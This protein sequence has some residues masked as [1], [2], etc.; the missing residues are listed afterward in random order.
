MA[1]KTGKGGFKENPQNI[2]KKGAPMRGESW[3]EI[4]DRVGKMTPIEAAEHAK[5]IA[6]KLK[7]MGG[8]MTLKEAVV[9]RGYAALLFEP[10]PGL[11]NVY[12]D[13][14]DGK[15]ETPIKHSGEVSMSWKEFI[16]DD[17][18]ENSG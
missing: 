16:S 11:M 3:A 2:N 5:A 12:M 17:T 18:E 10:S 14:N 15:V 8:D 13:R 6:G 4:I 7:S 9:I 1:N